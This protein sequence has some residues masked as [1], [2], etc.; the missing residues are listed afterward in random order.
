MDDREKKYD[1]EI[2]RTEEEKRGSGG[3]EKRYRREKED[4]KRNEVKLRKRI[5][6]IEG[7]EAKYREEE[8]RSE[9][10]RERVG[11]GDGRRK[12]EKHSDKRSEVS[13]SS[14]DN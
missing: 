4:W 8:I 5:E 2:G 6:E 12:K 1:K 13:T 14:S 7:G 9:E 11:G 3:W 10:E